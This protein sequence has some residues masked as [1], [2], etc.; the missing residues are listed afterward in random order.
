LNGVLVAI[1]EGETKTHLIVLRLG[2]KEFL[3]VCVKKIA[4]HMVFGN[5]E[6]CFEAL[7]NYR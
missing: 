7:G 2:L 1:G 4:V 3:S 5:E 6:K